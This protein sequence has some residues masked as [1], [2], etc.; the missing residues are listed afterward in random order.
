LTKDLNIKIFADVSSEADINA[1]SSTPYIQGFTTN[2]SLLKKA[3]V[4]N[5]EEFARNASKLAKDKGISFEVV[6]DSEET[7]LKEAHTIASWGENIF[8]KVPFLKTDGTDNSSTIKSL[9]KDGVK[10]N[11]TAIL[12]LEQVKKVADAANPEVPLIVSV[13]AGR[14]ADTG[15]DPEPLM[16]E[17]KK[18]I[19]HLPKA[20]LL[21]AS[22]RE[23]F[24]VIHAEKCGC[25]IIT[26]TPDLLAKFKLWG[27][28]LTEY[29][30][31]TAEMFYNDARSAGLVINHDST[32]QN[33]A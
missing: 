32:Y 29:S 31:Q 21:W 12:T 9:A 5:Y 23:I 1:F 19:Q 2:P 20:E 14:I 16:K 15:V 28:D 17:A 26:L 33:V 10:L 4:K 24:N 27:A 11:V 8:V 3:G 13:F 22:S 6:S 30:R 25:D 18:L 7:I